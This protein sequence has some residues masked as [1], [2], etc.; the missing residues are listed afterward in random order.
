M[1]S[2]NE[3]PADQK[4]LRGWKQVEYDSP[5]S[6]SSSSRRR[7]NEL[8]KLVLEEESLSPVA[9]T[10]FTR[11]LLNTCVK[12]PLIRNSSPVPQSKVNATVTKTPITQTFKS[13]SHIPEVT[14]FSCAR[15]RPIRQQTKQV[16]VSILLIIECIINLSNK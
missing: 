15:L 16:V 8:H 4:T 1:C 2:S 11:D 10:C 13:V 5:S 6:L 9:N 12:R 7:M 14:K 3:S